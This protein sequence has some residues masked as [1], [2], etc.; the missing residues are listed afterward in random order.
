MVA[1]LTATALSSVPA[2]HAG[3]ASG[4]NNAAARTAAL[5][6][7]AAVP[8]VAGLS[9]Q[10]YSRPASFDQGFDVAMTLSA[11]VF[12]AGAVVAAVGI[13]RSDDESI[14]G[15]RPAGTETNG[16]RAHQRHLPGASPHLTPTEMKVH[17][18]Q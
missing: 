10:V 5:L 8:A 11:V 6:A 3:L 4:V 1:P 7:I 13:G 14:R 15:R 16:T 9:G 18:E 2:E 12:A 17:H